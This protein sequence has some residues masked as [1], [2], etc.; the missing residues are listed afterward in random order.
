MER[1]LIAALDIYDA[2]RAIDL[3]RI[4]KDEIKAIKVNWPLI[5]SAGS[6]IIRDLSRFSPVLCDFKIADIPNTNRLITRKALEDGGWGIISHS[7]IGSDSLKAVIEESRGRMKV[8]SIVAMSHPGFK[9][10]MEPLSNDLISSSINCGVDGFIVP[11]NNYDVISQVKER[12]GGLTLVA[13][14]IGAQGGAADL[15]IRAGAD[16]VIVGRSLYQSDDPLKTAREIN[17]SISLIS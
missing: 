14:G 3:A 12:A 5:M 6:S 13:T 4:L 8:F 11:G 9:E 10:F 1:R 2:D 15:A 7:I 17:S 16:Y